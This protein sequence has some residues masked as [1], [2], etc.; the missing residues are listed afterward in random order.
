MATQNYKVFKRGSIIYLDLGKGIGHEF[1][2]KHFCLVITNKDNHR[3][4]KLTVIPLTSKSKHSEKVNVS[5]L[6]HFLEN[7]R[8][9]NNADKIELGKIKNKLKL[10]K[11][12]DLK[13]LIELSH[14]VTLLENSVGE[15]DAIESKINNLINKSSYAKTKDIIT[16]S[17][18]RILNYIKNLDTEIRLPKN[19]TDRLVKL[20]FDNFI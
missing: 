3:N 6:D 4:S 10:L 13:S 11:H 20:S 19:E 14:Q 18:N 17:K 16:I 7:Y 15:Y 2:F 1:S 9:K 5:L 12:G 8:N